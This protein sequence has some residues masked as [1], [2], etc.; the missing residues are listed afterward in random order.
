MA[1]NK[2]KFEICKVLRS[3]DPEG[4]DRI[5][6][7]LSGDNDKTDNELPWAHPLLPKVLHIKPKVGEIVIIFTINDGTESERFYIGPIIPQQVDTYFSPKDSIEIG[8]ARG[9]LMG[10][11]QTT[12]QSPETMTETRGALPLDEDITLEGRKN[13]GLQITDNDIRLK[14]GVKKLNTSD[15]TA[16]FNREDPAFIKLKYDDSKPENE[17]NS[18][19]Y[20][21]A[22]RINLLGS[23]P[24]GSLKDY[25]TDTTSQYKN[26]IR[27]KGKSGILKEITY[28]SFQRDLITDKEEKNILRTPGSDDDDGERYAYRMVY[29]EP[30]IEY[31]EMFR[32]AFLN[33]VHPFPTMTLCETDEIKN[34]KDYNLEDNLLSNTVRIN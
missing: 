31:L 4:G 12:A 27:G 21:V 18:V 9:F 11:Y 30:L 15:H 5:I 16:I 28:K 17:Y 2:S 6:A 33:H 23:N 24:G 19:A 14:A 1:D 22:D 34:F 10:P 25:K 26:I 32:D 3:E 8:E 13:C 20:I 7:R 29:G